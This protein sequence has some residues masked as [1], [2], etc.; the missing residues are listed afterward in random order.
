MIAEDDP[1]KN[2]HIVKNAKK[3]KP[4]RKRKSISS[5][6]EANLFVRANVKARLH[7]STT[8]GEKPK[9]CR[10]FNAFKLGANTSDGVVTGVCGDKHP[11]KKLIIPSTGICDFCGLQRVRRLFITHVRKI[12]KFSEKYWCL[13]VRKLHITHIHNTTNIS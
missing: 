12:T 1:Q 11:L 8:R 9:V 3:N 5:S 10:F 4:T 7:K 6:T 13:D 2:V